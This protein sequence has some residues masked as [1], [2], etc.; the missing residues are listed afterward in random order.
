MQSITIPPDKRY[1]T[2][3]TGEDYW[4]ARNSW[5]EGWGEN[6]YIR[7]KRESNPPCGTGT[8]KLLK[9]PV[10]SIYRN[11]IPASR[12]PPPVRHGMRG[13]QRPGADGL[14]TVRHPLRH[15]L[16]HRRRAGRQ[17]FAVNRSRIR[18]APTH[19]SKVQK[20]LINRLNVF[21]FVLPCSEPR[22]RRIF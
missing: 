6:G 18:F 8:F 4:L 5:G 3:E 11:L 2:T 1:G 14:R 17:R 15:F 16:P 7:M 9:Y 10:T 19:E 12:S 21:L 13:R 22:S 20:W